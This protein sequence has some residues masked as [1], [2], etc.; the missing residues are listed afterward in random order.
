MQEE[1]LEKKT[2]DFFLELYCATICNFILYHLPSGGLYLVGSLTNGLI[3]RMKQ[4][5]I[6][7]KFSERH[8]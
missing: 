3:E 2:V 1:T 7:E 4:I 6:V 8:P 5:N